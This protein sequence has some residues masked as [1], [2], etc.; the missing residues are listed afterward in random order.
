MTTET[1]SRSTPRVLLVGATSAMATAL[2][3]R[4]AAAG[5]RLVL[6]ARNEAA[7]SAL[8]TDLR[9]RGAAAVHV[10]PFD[11]A[12]SAVPSAQV[13]R[14]W[15]AF[16]GLDVAVLAHGV[17]PAQADAADDTA[18]ALAAFDINARSYLALLNELAPRF[19]Q[20]RRGVI[21]VIA[22]PAGERGRAS[23]YLYGCAKATLI[24]LAS[25]LRH[26]LHA[27]GVRVL[28]IQ[29]GFVDTPMTAAL[30]KSGPLWASP[31]RVAAEMYAALS[32]PRRN[33]TLYTPWFWWPIMFIVRALPERLFLRCKL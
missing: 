13:Q 24:N 17:M 20:Q 7:L 26:R 2:A 6:L 29:P 33:G 28:L 14:A 16:G 19:E 30:P 32:N 15:Q 4:Y 23:N 3:R 12:D 10:A 8:A 11:A 21:G 22:S 1:S 31:E 18:L 9:V 25:G 27:A 5:A